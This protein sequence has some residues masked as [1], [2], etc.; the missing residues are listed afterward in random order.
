MACRR[1]SLESITS[2]S[3]SSHEEA[4]ATKAHDAP[5]SSSSSAMR[6]G[7]FDHSRH[8]SVSSERSCEG[9]SADETRDLWRCMLQ[10]QELYGCYNS[11]RIDLAVAAGDEALN[12]MPNR[13]IIDTLNSSVVELPDEGWEML[14]KYLRHDQA[15]RPANQKPKHHHHHGHFWK[16]H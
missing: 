15:P 13:F 1:A 11:T 6:P 3:S 9:M 7:R 2:T 8:S 4:A 10:L 12:L 16:R 5:S 14:D